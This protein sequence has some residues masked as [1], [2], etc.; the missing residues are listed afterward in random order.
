MTLHLTGWDFCTTAS[1]C[2][3]VSGLFLLTA[4]FLIVFHAEDGCPRPTSRFL[5]PQVYQEWKK[6]KDDGDC[7]FVQKDGLSQQLDDTLRSI[8]ELQDERIKARPEDICCHRTLCPQCDRPTL[9]THMCRLWQDLRCP[10]FYASL[11][12]SG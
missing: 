1:R 10:G 7:M 8:M 5:P 6:A 4:Y 3:I 12:P 2:L 11:L 9:T